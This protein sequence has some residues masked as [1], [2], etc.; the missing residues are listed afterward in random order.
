[1]FSEASVEGGGGGG[2][3]HVKE[4]VYMMACHYGKWVCM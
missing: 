1:M 2:G 4:Q 3:M